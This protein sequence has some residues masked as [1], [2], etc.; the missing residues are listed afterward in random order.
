MTPVPGNPLHLLL[1]FVVAAHMLLVGAAAAQ[2]QTASLPDK[3]F[4][5]EFLV[6][7]NTVLAR[8]TVETAVM[9]FLGPDRVIADVYAARDAL[10]KAFE[11]AGF[12]AVSV[13]AERI[14]PV[15]TDT[16]PGWVAV[17]RVAQG[18]VARLKVTG[19]RYN[20]PSKVIE[21]TP[22]VAEGQVLNFPNLQQDL[23]RVAR[24]AGASVT[25][26]LRPGRDPGT[27]DVELKIKDELP[28]A[29]WAELSNDESADTSPRRLELGFR[30]DNLFQAQHGLTARFI[31]SPLNRDEVEVAT[32][33]YSLPFGSSAAGDD[34][35]S[36]YVVHSNS[37]VQADTGTGVIGKGD[38]LGLRWTRVFTPAPEFMHNLSLG[39]DFK[40]LQEDS[41][42]TGSRPL[43]YLP[44]SAQYGAVRPDDS[45]RWQFGAT[46]NAG[47]RVLNDRRVDCQ[48]FGG[49]DQFACK[50]AGASPS[51]LRWGGSL[52]REQR[53]DTFGL[54]G[55]R[56]EARLE[57]QFANEPLIGN[58]QFYIG[59]A[60]SV[61]G[62]FASEQ[63]GDDGARASFELAT[64]RLTPE[65]WP[66]VVTALAFVDA[67]MVRRREA[68]P[69]E[70]ERSGIA[71]AGLGLRVSWSRR[72]SGA[73]DVA[74]ALRAG[75]RTPDGAHRVHGNLRLEF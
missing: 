18:P 1:R 63:G 60:D 21:A 49:A 38:T 65:D 74:R 72:L 17:L 56:A 11:T 20:L 41:D 3:L 14:D 57:F 34:R 58:E 69:G 29:A 66:L 44:L 39:A 16:G 19:A 30:Y 33:S 52:Q 31:S 62:Y 12:L 8:T 13:D 40:A 47:L 67:G 2:A 70:T 75:T 28:L 24:F 59:G 48:G 25:P 7:G 26:V 68:L 42:A 55:W 73:L 22:S 54:A 46:L 43:H 51:F 61:R 9:P 6:E 27:M 37:R 10:A 36:L 35:L 5:S 53:L 64:P 50:R 45:G 23:A 32:L 4:I 15:V 71:G